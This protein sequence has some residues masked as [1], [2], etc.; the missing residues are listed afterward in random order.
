MK[1]ED[2]KVGMIISGNYAINNRKITAIGLY[3][4]L[5]QIEGS[6]DNE[7]CASLQEL[8]EFEPIAPKKR[9]WLWDVKDFG[10]IYKTNYYLDDVGEQTNGTCY[11]NAKDLIKKHENEFIDV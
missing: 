11:I 1:K 5:Y 3:T 6:E 10:G 2:L 4:Y 7:H 9:Y 8:D